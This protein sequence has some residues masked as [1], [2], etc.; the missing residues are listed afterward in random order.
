MEWI[1]KNRVVAIMIFVTMVLINLVNPLLSAN[2]K[3]DYIYYDPIYHYSITFPKGW[4][5]IPVKE[6]QFFMEEYK[7]M[8]PQKTAEVIGFAKVGFYVEGNNYFDYPYILVFNYEMKYR[9]FDEIAEE[10][11]ET[12]VSEMAEEINKEMQELVKDIRFDKPLIDIER[13][14]VIMKLH[15]KAKEL[16]DVITLMTICY[17]NERRVQLN[18]SS[19]ESEYKQYRPTF[20]S[21]YKSFKF[22]S[23][24]A[25]EDFAGIKNK[26][27][28][29][30]I[31]S[32]WI[33]IIVSGVVVYLIAYFS[34]KR[35]ERLKRMKEV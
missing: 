7:K 18:F 13:K 8:L 12:D 24:Y 34:K 32:G 27:M 26:H 17:G 15:G 29:K 5:R 30:I 3:K 6:F 23:G 28:R 9:P 2:K 20:Y 16:G 35:R 21:I 4:K 14:S 19:L 25:Y 10:Y 22:D 31:E 33:P 1:H 11:L